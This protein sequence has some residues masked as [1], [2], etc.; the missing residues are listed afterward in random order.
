MFSCICNCCF[1]KNT[2]VTI[3]EDGKIIKK[4]IQDVKKDELILTL[5]NQKNIFTKVLYKKNYDEGEYKFYEFKCYKGEN[6]KKILS[7]TI[8]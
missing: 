4:C 7:F 2:L 6:M 5:F 8:I 3:K 1:S